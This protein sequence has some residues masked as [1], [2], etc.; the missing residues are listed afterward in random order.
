[1]VWIPDSEVAE[2]K[3]LLAL[4]KANLIFKLGHPIRLFVCW[5]SNLEKCFLFDY[6]FSS[7]EQNGQKKKVEFIFSNYLHDM[8]PCIFCGVCV[9]GQNLIA[10]F[11]RRT[12]DCRTDRLTLSASVDVLLEM[13]TLESHWQFLSS[14]C[15]ASLRVDAVHCECRCICRAGLWSR[16]YAV[17]AMNK[18]KLYNANRNKT[19][20]SVNSPII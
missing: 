7:N 14:P 10:L 15:D 9:N 11:M 4:T 8:Q 17:V 5:C 18:I 2:W 19:K 16:L 3:L 13:F 12:F 1:M 6:F 20:S